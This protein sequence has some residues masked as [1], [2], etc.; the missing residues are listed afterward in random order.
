MQ[1]WGCCL[2]SAALLPFLPPGL[3]PVALRPTLSSGLPFR[4]LLIRRLRLR[5]VEAYGS[6]SRFSQ[7]IYV[8]TISLCPWLN[9]FYL[10]C[11]CP[12]VSVA[13]KIS[14]FELQ[15]SQPINLFLNLEPLS[16]VSVAN[17]G[18]AVNCSTT[19]TKSKIGAIEKV[20]R[21]FLFLD[22]NRNPKDPESP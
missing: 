13:N 17:Y 1:P 14:A 16:C 18:T 10:V 11:V 12:C 6:E 22:T 20:W 2:R 4:A 8:K 19:V 9:I 21:F 3:R 15:T 5:L 7:I